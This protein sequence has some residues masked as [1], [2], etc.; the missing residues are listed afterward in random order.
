MQNYL[1]LK[2]LFLLSFAVSLSAQE[3]CKVLLESINE[4][5]E[6]GCRRG[7][8]HGTGKAMGRDTFAGTFKKGLP[9]GKGTYTWANG[10]VYIGDFKKGKKQGRGT[11]T[12]ADG[13]VHQGYWKDDMYVG[14]D[15]KPYELISQNPRVNRVYFRRVDEGP[16]Q[17]DFQFTYLGRPVK[18][19]NLQVQNG[20]GVLIN[21]TDYLKSVEVYRFPFMGEV[22]VEV[23][24]APDDTKGM[25]RQWWTANI[26]FKINQP[27]KWVVTIE[28]RPV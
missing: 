9:H 18:G 12:E 11:L 2:I 1:S 21:E 3:T 6:G 4:Q 17:V 27:G 20:F 23:E 25:P 13:T 19:R 15:K 7:L 16:H 26:T 5:Y 24:S 14:E 8:A 22:T 10:D 28:M